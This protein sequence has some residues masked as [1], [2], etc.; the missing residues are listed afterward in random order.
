MTVHLARIDCLGEALRDACITYKSNTAL[1]EADRHR[2]K[3]QLTYLQLKR[4]AERVAARLQ[5]LGVGPGDRVGILMSNQSAWV[6]SGMAALWSGAVLV[7]LDYKLTA[8]E[9]LAL[10]AHAKPKVLITEYPVLRDFDRAGARP[11]ASCSL[12]V[13]E[14]PQRAELGA[15]LRWEDAPEGAFTYVARARED[16]ASIVYSSGTGGKPKGCM[17]AHE[18][19]LSQAQV[20]SG[21]F[22]MDEGDRYFSVLPTNHAIDFMCGMIIPFLFGAGV[23]HQ[24]TL[25]PEFLA[26]TMKRYRVTHT[27]L[28]PRILKSLKE[29]IDERLEDRPEWQRTLLMGLMRTNDV[30]TMREPSH[31]LS[32]KLLWPIHERFGGH[33]RQIVVGGTFVDPELA[34][35]FYRL[36][37]PCAIGYG[38]TEAC[39]VLTVND[40]KPF[41]STTVGKPVEGVELELRDVGEGG[42]G[43]VYARGPSIMLGYLDEPELTAETLVAGWLRTG[44]LGVLDA[45]GHLKLVGRSKN[46]IVTEGGK[47]IYPE[48]IEGVFEAVP[49]E[50]LCVFAANYLW[51]KQTLSGEELTVVVRP[52][53]GQDVAEL[54]QALVE[55]NRKLVDY[56]RVSSFVLWQEEFPHTASMKTKRPKLAEQVREAGAAASPLER[57]GAA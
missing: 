35:Y 52:K 31:A 14:A 43:E 23:V 38:L 6:I 15:A 19:Y 7:P 13:T 16:L 57:A 18:S 51:P 56:K 46:M 22:P 53:K 54:L 33:L 11:D 39:T 4:E 34:E 44:D 1:F 41:R 40:L 20:L 5:A 10:V 8:P 55:Q 9:Q 29:R 45:S 25:R 36:G 12:L 47:N 50:E 28:V 24:R 37:L 30:V 2:E 27:A 42:I 32:K 17:L 21:M 48:D 49:C 26:P 3:R